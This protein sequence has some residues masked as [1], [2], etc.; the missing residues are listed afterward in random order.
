MFYLL[1]KKIIKAG[2]F[3]NHMEGVYLNEKGRTYFVEELE[4]KIC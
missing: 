3:D 2:H 1:N 4:Y